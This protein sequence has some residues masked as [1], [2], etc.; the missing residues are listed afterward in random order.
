MPINDYVSK[1]L[2]I[3]IIVALTSI[4]L[5]A[6]LTQQ[7][8][9][10]EKELGNEKESLLPIPD[11]QMEGPKPLPESQL[12]NASEPPVKPERPASE[13]K[14]QVMEPSSMMSIEVAFPNLSLERMVYLTHSGDGTNRIFVVL[15]SGVIIVDPNSPKIFLDIS[16]RVSYTGNEEGLLGLAFDPDYGMNGHF[17]LYYTD[18][19]TRDSV[20]SRF[21]VSPDQINMA[22][23]NSE[24]KLLQLNQPYS[25]HNGGSLAFGHD[26]YLYL[27]LGDGGAGGDP[28]RHGQNIETL[29][30]SILRI[31]TRASSNGKEY[32]VPP[33]NPFDNE[34]WAFGFRNPWRFSF[35]RE[36]GML[37][38][39]DVGQNEFEEVDL[40]ERG[41][42]YGWNTME[43]F[44]CFSPSGLACEASGLVLPI[45]EYSHQ[46]GC[47][48]T[49]GYVYRGSRIPSL[50]G[51]YV[52]GDFCSGKIWALRFDGIQVTEHVEL[53]DSDLTISSFG[54]DEDG[55]LYILSF[56]G[57]IYRMTTVN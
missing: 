48:I 12:P 3:L 39:G 15:Q 24:L 56:D 8:V 37:C 47:S 34:I 54:E 51:A 11:V 6:V 32:N 1:S 19:S 40:V 4:G 23:P 45:V 18:Y 52:Y 57:K 31:D 17:Y 14:S 43:G 38:V 41:G 33:D 5:V 7:P 44:H 42:N 21:S 10:T 27:G 50:Y 9:M 22:D 26:G 13:H 46:D 49:G 35:D 20:L 2:L 28:H 29:L 25:N 55:E 36:T 30:G 53:M 16:D